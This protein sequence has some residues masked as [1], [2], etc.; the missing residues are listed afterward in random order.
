MIR[1]FFLLAAAA[2]GLLALAACSSEEGGQASPTAPVVGGAW[3][4]EWDQVLEAAKRE[5]KVAVAGPAGADVREALTEPF[6]KKYGI[7]VEFLAQRGGEFG[8]RVREERGA[9]QYLWDVYMGGTTTAITDFREELKGLEPLEPMLILPDI[10][11]SKN[12][13]AG[14]LPWSDK[15]RVSFSFTGYYTEAFLINPKMVKPEEFKSYKDLLDPKWKGKLIIDDPRVSGGG[16][17]KFHFFFVHKDLGRDFIRAL[18]TQMEPTIMR[19][20]AQQL[21]W[22]AEGRAPI[23]I[24]GSKTTAEPMIQAGAP[25]GFVDPSKFKEGPS[26]HTGVGNVSI[27]KNAPHPNAAKLYLNWLLSKEGQVQFVKANGIPS[28]RMDVP[29]DK[30]AWIRPKAGD[31]FVDLDGEDAVWQRRNDVL[32][33]LQSVLGR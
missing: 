15:D 11:D 27:F 5:G 28:R 14:A 25:I 33:F 21:Q 16:Q 4:R 1:R 32:P 6:Q 19:D 18:L 13:L 29:W 26:L 8:T 24:G 31:V 20:R 30:D 12:W 23:L 10:K 17:A 9:G 7:Q 2:L 3:Q 22:L